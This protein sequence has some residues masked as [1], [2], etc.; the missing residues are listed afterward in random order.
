ML[1]IQTQQKLAELLLTISEGERLIE[2][3]R[4]LLSFQIDIRSLFK[5]FDIGQ[6]GIVDLNGIDSYLKYSN[7]IH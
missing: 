6:M 7:M 3:N 2:V 4:Q 5:V 1:S